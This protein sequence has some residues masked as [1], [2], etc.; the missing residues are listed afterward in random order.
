MADTKVTDLDR[1]NLHEP[2]STYLKELKESKDP[3]LV[4]QAAYAYQA[5]LC[6]PDN[7]TAWQAAVRRTGEVLFGLSGIAS[8]MKDLNLVKFIES[9]ENLQKGVAG[10][11]HIV[12]T[13]YVGVVSLAESGQS[14]LE[15]LK[16]SFKSKGKCAWY[17]ALRGA[18]TLIRNRKLA[19]FK[20][21]VC[22]APCRL[23]PAFQWG[24]C[25]R[26]GEM[27][28][29]KMWDASIRRNAIDFLGEI[30]RNDDVWG[31]HPSV[32][33]W[34]LN[35]LMQLASNSQIG[36]QYAGALLCELESSGDDKK[37]A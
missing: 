13:A 20:R 5:I 29:N 24:V 34:I 26:L 36:P 33:Q 15:C 18:D 17:S 2:L 4:Y 3:Y 32:K 10:T 12:A 31:Q 19:S 28:A 6:V 7:E 9:L 22:E 21:L 11:V 1:E 14:L 25:Q 23:D 30:Y 27:A 35:I 8:A 16:E 37:Q